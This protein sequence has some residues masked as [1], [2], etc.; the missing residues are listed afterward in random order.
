MAAAFDDDITM[1]VH[2]GC[3]NSVMDPHTSEMMRVRVSHR[4]LQTTLIK[5][6]HTAAVRRMNGSLQQVTEFTLI[7]KPQVQAER[8]KVGAAE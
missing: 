7:S 5:F 3:A 4:C 6:P 8:I 1:G 2:M